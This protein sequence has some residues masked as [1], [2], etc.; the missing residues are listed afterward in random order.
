ML[1][2][3]VT[4]DEDDIGPLAY[5]HDELYGAYM[6][7]VHGIHGSYITMLRP[8]NFQT[9]EAIPHR[10]T[11][12]RQNR[13]TC[14][15]KLREVRWDTWRACLM[16]GRFLLLE[17]LCDAPTATLIDHDSTTHELPWPENGRL[18]FEQSV[19]LLGRLVFGIDEHKLQDLMA[20]FRLVR[21]RLDLHPLWCP[22]HSSRCS[23]RCE[24][25]LDRNADWLVWTF[26]HCDNEGNEW[27]GWIDFGKDKM[28][29]FV[30]VQGGEARRVRGKPI[31]PSPLDFDS[32]ILEAFDNAMDNAPW[33]ENEDAQHDEPLAITYHPTTYR[34][35]AA[36]AAARAAEERAEAL[37]EEE[38]FMCNYSTPCEFE[39]VAPS[40]PVLPPQTPRPP[41]PDTLHEMLVEIGGMCALPQWHAAWISGK[42]GMVEAADTPK[43]LVEELCRRY[44]T[45]TDVGYPFSN[46][47]VVQDMLRDY[48]EGVAMYPRIEA[49]YKA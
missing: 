21:H 16:D 22:P 1:S 26:K 25:M 10:K 27:E 15:T 9:G 38:D 36:M 37:R 47:L 48:L 44:N 20:I 46:R 29:T 14:E 43:L 42:Q 5:T 2:Y 39:R 45:Q 8:V 6:E 18:A 31:S 40:P 28:T 33:R 30:S 3:N 11:C 23:V 19:M 4:M 41:S 13:C 32:M 34:S 49:V 35:E 12:K 17:K 7:S 24:C